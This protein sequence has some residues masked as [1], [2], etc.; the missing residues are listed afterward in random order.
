MSRRL[1]CCTVAIW[2]AAIA[3]SAEPELPPFL[4]SQPKPLVLL[5]A[6]PDRLG[7]EFVK[8]LDQRVKEAPVAERRAA[9]AAWLAEI[10]APLETPACRA[11]LNSLATPE[12]PPD[13][14]RLAEGFP[15]SRPIALEQLLVPPEFPFPAA[16]DR[17]F[18]LATGLIPL[19]VALT[20]EWARL[21]GSV[22]A[23]PPPRDP[24]LRLTRAAR[25]EG[26]AR[27][28]GVFVTVQGGGVA[29][30][31]LGAGLLQAD[32]DLAG[33]PRGSYEAAITGPIARAL[34][35][36]VLEDGSRWVTL[37]FVAG[38]WPAVIAALERPNDRPSALYRLSAGT[39]AKL[40]SQG[41]RL[42][43]RGVTALLVGD[44]EP[45]W[46]TQILDD[47]SLVAG[48][49]LRT[50]LLLESDDAAVRVEQELIKQGY[51]PARQAARI[52]LTRIVAVTPSRGN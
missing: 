38:G 37:R 7:G 32:R 14:A 5:E 46:T 16:E 21:I 50:E 11:V 22:H 20:G 52:M 39:D 19:E 12:P 49:Q 23:G 47:V 13:L 10:F 51:Q 31:D 9:A 1:A 4:P 25:L 15:E 17:E 34:L 26:L 28:A 45:S 24:L 29:A 41:C 2:M 30:S 43:P 6:V 35:L 40:D 27:M 33:L 36:T 42:G 48:N 3:L 44:S 8:K 18:I